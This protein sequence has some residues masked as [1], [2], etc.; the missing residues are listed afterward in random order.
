MKPSMMKPPGGK[1]VSKKPLYSRITV[2]SMK[3]KLS[4][5]NTDALANSVPAELISRAAPNHHRQSEP[6]THHQAIP[7]RRH[8]G[9]FGGKGFGAAQNHA[10]RNDQRDK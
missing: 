6:K 4:P 7:H 1:A 10:I 5:S 9:L 8:D 3:R 2:S